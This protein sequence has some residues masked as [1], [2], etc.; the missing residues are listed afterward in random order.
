MPC[1]SGYTDWESAPAPGRRSSGR[2]PGDLGI[3]ELILVDA[4]PDTAEECP[5]WVDRLADRWI[6]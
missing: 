5:V 6:I 4:P 3:T 2:P 1:D